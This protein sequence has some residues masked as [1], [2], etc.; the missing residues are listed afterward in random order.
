MSESHYVPL[1][2]LTRGRV[3]E[4]LHYGALA[5]VDRSGRLLAQV[6]SANA[7]TFLRST[8]KPFQALPFVEGGGLEHFGLNLQELALICASHSGTDQHAAVVRQVQQ[9][10]GIQESDLLCGV[11]PPTDPA[12]QE[13]L[14]A[15][16][17]AVTPNRHNC[18][19]K[20][21]GMLAFARLLG[22]TLEEYIDP[23]HPVQQ[24]ILTTFAEMC[25]L[26]PAQVELGIDGCSAPNFAVPLH[27]A[28]LAFAR[29]CDP[30]E[31]APQR[32]AACRT[33]TTAMTTYPQMVAGPN[34]FDTD[35]MLACQGRLVTKGGAEGYTGIGLL[36]GAL[37]AGSPALGIAL[38][39]ADGDP[40]GRART[41]AA[42]E[43]LRQLG[44]LSAGQLEQLAKY[45]PQRPIENWRKLEVGRLYPIFHLPEI[46][47]SSAA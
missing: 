46:E 22:V 33:I 18:S 42:L 11:H 1:I 25:G 4:S 15:R 5:V 2:E 43:V 47:F 45:G 23:A 3:G 14:R 6:G 20:H 37:G 24:R 35:L 27:S 29:L 17:E 30:V 44:A 32:A 13:A 34:R 38:K 40:T 26:E 7:V 10:A 21:S 41:A 39:I 9:K 31:L 8:A 12:T 19:G 16:G 28:A 36:P